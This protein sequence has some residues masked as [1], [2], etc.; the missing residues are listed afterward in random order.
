MS[1]SSLDLDIL[2]CEIIADC[3]TVTPPPDRNEI[4]SH[5]I[6]HLGPELRKQVY[7]ALDRMTR[8]GMV[9]RLTAQKDDVQA[10]RYGL[11]ES[12]SAPH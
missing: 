1:I 6:D 2:I 3:A 10:L 11:P 5:V 4:A 8:T 7:A 12:A 9:V